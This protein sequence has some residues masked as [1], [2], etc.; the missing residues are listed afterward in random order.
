MPEILLETVHGSRLY[1]T[2][3]ADSDFDTYRVVLKGKNYQKVED[4]DDTTQINLKTF[5][6]QVATGVPQALEALWSPHAKIN[7]YWQPLFDSLKPPYYPTLATFY[8]AIQNFTGR[9]SDVRPPTPKLRLHAIRLAKERSDFQMYGKFSPVVNPK[10][11]LAWKIA[12]ERSSTTDAALAR[13]G[14]FG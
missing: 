13:Y 9:G 3:E 6:G 1:G 7:V 2:F 8:R 11:V 12:A 5:L 10:L 14:M 4:R